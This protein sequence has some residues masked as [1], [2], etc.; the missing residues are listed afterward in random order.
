MILNEEAYLVLYD[1]SSNFIN[2]LLLNSAARIDAFCS[3]LCH[4]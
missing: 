4:L 3:L 2:M 1:T